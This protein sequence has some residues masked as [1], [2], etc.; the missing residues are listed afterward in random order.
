LALWMMF[1]MAVPGFVTASI[2]SVPASHNPAALFTVSAISLAA[3]V[4]VGIYQAYTIIAKR[5]NPL[6]DELY[7]DHRGYQEVLAANLTPASVPA[8]LAAVQHS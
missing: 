1:T 8:D 5:K 3:N 7:S 6:T 2:F 4:A